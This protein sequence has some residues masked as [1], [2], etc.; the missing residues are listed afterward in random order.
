[1]K[2][3]L[4]LTLVFVF[5]L[6]ISIFVLYNTFIKN[7]SI[8]KPENTIVL[9]GDDIVTLPL[10]GGEKIAVENFLTLPEVSPDSYNENLYSLGNT[11]N[12]AT[13]TTGDSPYLITFDAETKYFNIVLLKKPLASIRLATEAYMKQVLDISESQMCELNY[14]LSVPGYVDEAASSIDYRFSFC[15]DS[16]QL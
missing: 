11:F 6:P 5:F 16:V 4:L 9:P 1:M 10:S 7:V 13:Q 8:T 15:P 14:M 12:S 3:S 2:F